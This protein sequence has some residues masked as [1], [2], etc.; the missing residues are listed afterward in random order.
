MIE[1]TLV[2]GVL[3]VTPDS[4]SDGGKY[5]ATADAIAHGEQLIA[6]GAD[7]LDIGGESTRP[8]A[9]RPSTEEE[10]ARV[11]PVVQALA[12]HGV[13]ISVDTMRRE[14]AAAVIEAGASI[15]NDVS[16]GLAD[17]EILPV[18]AKT[19]VDYI[20]QHWRGHGAVMDSLA[21][22]QQLMPE[23]ITELTNRRDAAI[24]AGISAERII[25]DPGF[26]FA[27]KTE[28]NWEILAK[29]AQLQELGHR[30]LL[31]ASRKRFLTD[32]LSQDDLTQRDIATATISAWA[33]LNG[34]WAV[35]THDILAQRTAIE[36]ARNIRSAK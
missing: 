5:F 23:L 21:N 34:I 20:C 1:R 17:P 6:Q 22:Y 25:L 35:R 8:G 28:D 26:G 33:Q 31:G 9:S 2:M 36:V 29:L 15:I 27:K 12:V 19:N 24:A 14:V 10:L 13:P 4:F 18:V 11:V 3:N 16:G 7:L 30:I 32:T